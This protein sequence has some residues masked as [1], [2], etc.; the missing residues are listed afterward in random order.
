MGQEA[1][2]I[3]GL[4]PNI[5]NRVRGPCFRCGCHSKLSWMQVKVVP[6]PKQ[7]LPFYTTFKRWDILSLHY[8]CS[9]VQCT[10]KLFTWCIHC[11]HS[12]P[13]NS[14]SL[15]T[16]FY[17]PS[18]GKV[19]SAPLENLGEIGWLGRSE[20]STT[21]L[22]KHKLN[23]AE[24]SISQPRLT[25]NMALMRDISASQPRLM[26][27]NDEGCLE[28]CQMSWCLVSDTVMQL[29]S[30]WNMIQGYKIYLNWLSVIVSF[31]T[32]IVDVWRV[33]RLMTEKYFNSD[34]ISCFQTYRLS[35]FACSINNSKKIKVGI[36][37][38]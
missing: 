32:L 7:F 5:N 11:T 9:T 37:K 27:L 23:F 22:S 19:K 2:K 10:Y 17:F 12:A 26:R 6:V 4:N 20:I 18:C 16:G 30:V 34:K 24:R 38:I 35:C 28:E 15:G 31:D 25:I 13:F 1:S 29:A 14:D 8:I 21:I 33:V 3:W 36:Q